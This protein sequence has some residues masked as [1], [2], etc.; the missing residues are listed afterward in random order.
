[1]TKTKQT[2]KRTRSPKK[3]TT[4]AISRGLVVRLE[5]F[6]ALLNS[7]DETEVDYT[8]ATTERFQRELVGCLHGHEVQLALEQQE[9]RRA[10]RMA[11]LV[12][13]VHGLERALRAAQ[14]SAT[15][16]LSAPQPESQESSA[17]QLSVAR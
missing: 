10:P 7:P 14:R 11:K 2:T 12:E 5:A 4:V 15:L 8:F 6:F 9:R 13:R 17:P 3:P 16:R 1:M